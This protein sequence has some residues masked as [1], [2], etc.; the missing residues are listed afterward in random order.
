V[1]RRAAVLPHQGGTLDTAIFG[2]DI[3]DVVSLFMPP[4]AVIKEL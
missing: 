2:L 3:H 4:E 1:C